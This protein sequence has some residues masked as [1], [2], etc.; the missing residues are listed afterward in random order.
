MIRRYL[1]SQNSHPR[2]MVSVL[3]VRIPGLFNQ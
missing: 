3:L 2:G 1:S